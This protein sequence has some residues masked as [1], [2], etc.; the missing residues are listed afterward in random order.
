VTDD[1]D[2]RC[3]NAILRNFYNDAAVLPGY[4]FQSSGVGADL[5][6]QPTA[7]TYEEY[8]DFLRGLPA[9]SSP[10]VFGLHSNAAITKELKET[11]ELFDAIL[12]TQS[13]V[14][15]GGGGG[16]SLLASIAEDIA[17]KLPDDFDL[18]A[19]KAMYPVQYLQ[20][21]NTVLSQELIRFNRLIAIVRKSLADLKKAIK[22][23]VV[24]DADLEALATAL[25]NAQRP[26][27]WMKRSYPSLK[28]LGGYVN[29]L[30]RRLSFFH[31]WID[32]GIPKDFWISG[33]FFT[34]AFLT[35]AMQ[36]YAR[37][38]KVSIDEVDFEFSMMTTKPG[39]GTPAPE[40]G[41]HVYG[42]FLEG[43]RY[44]ATTKVLAECEPKVLFTDIPMMW[45]RPMV[46][47][48]IPQVPHY[49]CPL[50][51]ESA[52]RGVLATTGHSSNFVMY[53]KLPSDKDESHWVKR[54]VAGLCALDD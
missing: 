46:V 52:R 4:Q 13:R 23:L 47:D 11:R 33:F 38:N 27:M 51:K 54:G 28:P 22:G 39:D 49:N 5:Y 8:L 42:L 37:S 40:D 35:G 7:D 26:A 32:N 18:D 17:S 43:A 50:Y 25:I 36:N 53:L 24:M 31:D 30:L 45:F 20:S 19:V 10:E 16:D 9:F 44:D 1:K 2:R 48:D 29:D 21:M 6:V 34:Q 12:L 14:G 41:V 15:G 3:L